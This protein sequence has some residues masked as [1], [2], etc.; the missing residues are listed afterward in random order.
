MTI[1][2]EIFAHK[3]IEVAAARAVKPLVAMRAAA[4]SA[5]APLDFISALMKKPVVA[6]RS[7][8][9]ALIAEV[10][11][12]SPSRGVLVANPDPVGLARV[13]AEN[14][15]AA[16]SVLTDEQY[17]RGHI[18]YLSQIYAALPH[19]PLLRKDFILDPYQVYE[20]RAACASAVLLIAAYLDTVLMADLHA[21]ILELGMAPLVEVH[22][23]QELET[24]LK[25]K[26][27]LIGVNN[28]DLRDFTVNLETCLALRRYV[29]PSIGFV[30]ES[31]IHTPQDVRQLG[32]AGVNAMLIGEAL[33]TA[34]DVGAKVR[35]LA[36]PDS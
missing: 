26:P 5:P 23:R 16:I 22:N 33:V 17:F 35:E 31:G 25:V 4:E 9:P 1:L 34:G 14:G 6:Q 28:R 10:K 7:P 2:D 36:G 18:A 11:F 21:L 27:F 19:I 30:A 3:K 32:A 29:P 15:A 24:T 20:A 12:A 13:Y 8:V